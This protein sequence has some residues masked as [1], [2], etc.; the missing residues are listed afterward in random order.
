MKIL[1]ISQSVIP[2]K[3]ANSIHAMKMCS[4]LSNLNNKVDLFCWNN[5]RDVEK[6]IEDFYKFYSVDENFNI[7]RLKVQN[8]W[9]LREI[10]SL[11]FLLYKIFINHYDLIYCR[12]IQVS[13]FLSILGIKTVLEIHSP[14]SIKTNYFFKKILIKG[15]LF[16][17]SS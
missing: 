4:A 16:F 8:F 14:P 6:N 13:W 1:Y 17:W 15:N 11:I 7:L 2:S 5:N 9:F 10:V 12:N 3:S